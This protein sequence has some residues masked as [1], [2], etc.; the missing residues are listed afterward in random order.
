MNIVAQEAG[1][2]FESRAAKVSNRVS[3]YRPIERRT[4]QRETDR[5]TMVAEADQE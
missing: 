4:R 5:S 1:G 2:R 3:S